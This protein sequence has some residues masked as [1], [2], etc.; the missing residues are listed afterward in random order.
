M[1]EMMEKLPAE[2][3]T[4]VAARLNTNLM[5]W[6]TTVD[7]QG[8]PD[9]VPVWFSVGDD[10]R[11]LVYT[12]PGKKKL[13]NLG[14]NPNVSLGL[15]V[16][17]IGRDVI[18]IEGTACHEANHPRADQVPEYCSK[19]A[20]RSAAIFGTIEEFAQIFSEAIIITPSRLH[21]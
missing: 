20:E 7:A 16:T 19:Y 17:D 8:R 21:A 15:D 9:C 10:D 11:L 3:R 4:R 2:R 1:I 13:R 14:G 18:R 12:Q 5:A 6:L